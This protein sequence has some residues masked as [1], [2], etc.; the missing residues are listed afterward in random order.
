MN[1]DIACPGNDQ[2]ERLKI[3]DKEDK[4]DGSSI[5][6]PKRLALILDTI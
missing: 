4:R 5:S 1:D 6:E 3:Q 2:M